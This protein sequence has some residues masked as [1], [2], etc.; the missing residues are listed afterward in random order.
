MVMICQ[1]VNNKEKI[2]KHNINFFLQY[3][4]GWQEQDQ[5]SAIFYLCVNWQGKETERTR[6][7][8]AFFKGTV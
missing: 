5:A 1:A 7:A 4:L 6:Q 2:K 3:K 8:S